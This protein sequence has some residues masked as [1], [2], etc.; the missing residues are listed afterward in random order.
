LDQETYY[1]QEAYQELEA[2]TGQEPYQEQE[3]EYQNTVQNAGNDSV[4][5]LYANDNQPHYYPG[6]C[7]RL[8]KDH[9]ITGHEFSYRIE[10]VRPSGDAVQIIR[11]RLI[12]STTPK[13]TS[14]IY[15]HWM[16]SYITR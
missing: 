14:S 12:S 3:A 16:K 6:T 4:W 1:V 2:Y 15:M 13:K 5:I 7:V 10:I 11:K 8:D 9:L